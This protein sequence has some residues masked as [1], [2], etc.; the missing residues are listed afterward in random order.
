LQRERAP[1]TGL[2]AHAETVGLRGHGCLLL[3]GE[4]VR[5]D[6]PRGLDFLYSRNRLNMAVSRARCLAYVVASPRLLEVNCKT[7]DQ[8]RLVNALCR[9][10][11]VAESR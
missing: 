3:D 5:E 1:H 4:F 6:A 8:M 10:A 9:F 2:I 7:V 11:E